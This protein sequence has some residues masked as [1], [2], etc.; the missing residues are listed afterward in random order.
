MNESLSLYNYP[1]STTK[2]IV[3]GS[4]YKRNKP[5]MDSAAEEQVTTDGFTKE[6]NWNY[7]KVWMEWKKQKSQNR[8]YQN[9]FDKRVCDCRKRCNYY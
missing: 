5:Q 3:N 7:K 9:G 8:K 6:N 4:L 1:S 2:S